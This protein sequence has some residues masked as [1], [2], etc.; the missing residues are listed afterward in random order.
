M[1]GGHYSVQRQY[2]LGGLIMEILKWVPVVVVLIIIG[3]IQR[4]VKRW[5]ED[6]KLEDELR[7]QKKAVDKVYSEDK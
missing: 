2:F 7:R 6:K 1:G 3:L 5:W 4:R